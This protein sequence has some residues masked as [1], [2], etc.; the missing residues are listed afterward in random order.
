MDF[1]VHLSLE[2]ETQ[3][4]GS[5]RSNRVRGK[6]TV[7][8]E[9]AEEWL[10]YT[11][12]FEL[13]PDLLIPDTALVLFEI[14]RTRPQGLRLHVHTWSCLC[15]G[16][17]LLWLGADT[18]SMRSD[19]WI[20]VPITPEAG[21]E[22]ES[23]ATTDLRTILSHMGEWLPVGELKGQRLFQ[24]ELKELGLLDDDESQARL[25]EM[26]GGLS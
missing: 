5:A 21:D 10:K 22:E 6:E 9:H 20:Q 25:L 11:D 18:R 4:I 12:R 15:D 26:F 23:P 2:G 1:E 13:E 17:A 14:L 3:R 19:A 7:V 16:S 8:F 24:A